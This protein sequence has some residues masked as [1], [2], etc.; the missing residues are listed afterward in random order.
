MKRVNDGKSTS[1]LM[2]LKATSTRYIIGTGKVTWQQYDP[3]NYEL[4]IFKTSCCSRM[5]ERATGI[6]LKMGESAELK[7]SIGKVNSPPV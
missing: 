6:K 3:P 7:V 1:K 2:L 4:S 5:F